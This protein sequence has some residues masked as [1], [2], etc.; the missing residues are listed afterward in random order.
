LQYNYFNKK[1]QP[2][3]I[4]AQVNDEVINDEEYT[5]DVV[6]ESFQARELRSI[7]LMNS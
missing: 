5:F 2:S 6:G 7:N 1:I 4:P 3:E